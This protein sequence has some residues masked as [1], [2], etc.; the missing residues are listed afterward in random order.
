[1]KNP[2][3]EQIFEAC[4]AGRLD[5]ELEELARSGEGDLAE[6]VRGVQ[7]LCELI[8][9][10]RLEA[11][12]LAVRRAALELAKPDSFLEK[13]KVWLASLVPETGTLRPAF[14]GAAAA[15]SL[16][17]AGPFELDVLLNE[18]GNLIGELDGDCDSSLDGVC[19]LFG[20]DGVRSLPVQDGEFRIES[21][22]PGTYRLLIELDPGTD[23]AQTIVI[24]DLTI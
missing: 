19:S 20:P 9:E 7:R 15:P 21:V 1:M 22:E 8:Q 13:A 5:P 16:Y 4:L 24:E 12:P 11:P 23:S 6:Q 17:Q 14:R 10:A 3:R 18:S 2:S